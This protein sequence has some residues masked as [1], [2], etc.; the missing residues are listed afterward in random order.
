MRIV[1]VT[2][3]TSLPVTLVECKQWMRILH[4]DED[5]V[6]SQLLA[7][8]CDQV[9]RLTRRAL[10]PQALRLE[11][12]RWPAFRC[13]EIPRP[14]LGQVTSVQYIDAGGDLQTLDSAAYSVVTGGPNP[15]KIQLNY[16][17]YWPAVEPRREEAIRVNY[18]AG[19]ANAA[20]VPAAIKGAIQA[21]IEW[22]FDNRAGV[23]TDDFQKE[24][25]RR[26]AGHRVLSFAS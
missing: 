16:G 25:L 5:A 20:A 11:R 13:L 18:T 8:A 10:M 26:I 17:E 6:I 23:M 12:D 3:A 24:I 1:V 9:E 7:S 22:M 14:P 19:Y 4:S 21:T 15:A 2:P